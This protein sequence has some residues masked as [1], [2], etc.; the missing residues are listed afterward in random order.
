MNKKI[1]TKLSVLAVIGFFIIAIASK[2]S[3]M[4]FGNSERWIPKDFD[5]GKTT[6]LVEK[7]FISKRGEKKMEDYM[8]EKYPYKYEFVPGEVITK[9]EGKY[10]DTKL[11]KYAL[12]FSSH[13]STQFDVQTHKPGVTVTGF[14]FHFYD[15]ELKKDYPA[16]GK[17]SSYAHMTFEPVI[18][19]IVKKFK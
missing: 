2:P 7:F 5:P 11:Y 17:P 13:T 4:T 6:L 10:A 3:K 14:D 12:M 8:A 18:N 19:T 9:R 15:R 1:K 16:T